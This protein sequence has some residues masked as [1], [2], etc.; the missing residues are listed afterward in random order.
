MASAVII[1]YL[2]FTDGEIEAQ[3]IF[4]VSSSTS[5]ASGSSKYALK[6]RPALLTDVK[7]MH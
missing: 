4:T 3:G 6:H 2:Y 1:Y 7:S 5:Q